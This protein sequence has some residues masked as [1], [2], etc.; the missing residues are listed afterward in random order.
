MNPAEHGISSK[1]TS[2][3]NFRFGRQNG[4][5]RDHSPLSPRR[6]SRIDIKPCDT[7][8]HTSVELL[9]GRLDFPSRCVS[10]WL[11]LTSSVMRLRQKIASKANDVRKRAA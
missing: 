5:D 9:A 7:L 4:R 10:A 1:P 6:P 3:P 11:E 8:T 2:S